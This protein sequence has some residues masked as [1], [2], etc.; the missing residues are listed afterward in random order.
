MTKHDCMNFP[1]YKVAY[2]KMKI[3]L[4]KSFN[5]I[6]ICWQRQLSFDTYQNCLSECYLD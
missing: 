2:A 6:K 4:L 5:S 1:K 3:I